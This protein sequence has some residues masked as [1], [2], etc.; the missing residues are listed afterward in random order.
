MMKN[1]VLLLLTTATVFC[2]LTVRTSRAQAPGTVLWTFSKA[3]DLSG[4]ALDFNGTVYTVGSD[5]IGDTNYMLYALNPTGSLKWS[6]PCPPLY[7]GDL[8]IGAD[9]SIYAHLF[10]SGAGGLYAFD[11]SGSIRW[12]QTNA[13]TGS[14]SPAIG[15][16]GTVYYYSDARSPVP[17]ASTLCAIRPDGT[18]KWA[19]PLGAEYAGYPVVGPDGTIYAVSGNAIFA[20]NPDGTEKWTNTNDWAGF[21][22]V[23][24]E[25]VLYM[26]AW[27]DFFVAVNPN[28]TIRW[29]ASPGGVCFPVIGPDGIIYFGTSSAIYALT[30]EGTTN[31]VISI[32]QNMG[33]P[34]LGPDGA[35]YV[36]SGPNW[37]QT[38]LYCL[39]LD[40]ST[41]WQAGL[42]GSLIRAPIVGP[43][44]I[45]YCFTWDRLG[46][47]GGRV[48][49]IKGGAGATPAPWPSERGNFRNTARDDRPAILL[50]LVPAGGSVQLSL[51]GEAGMPFRLQSSTNLWAW[52]TAASGTFTNASAQLTVPAATNSNS[53][54]FRL[55]VP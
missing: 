50:P 20:I 16:D 54:F 26:G 17:T 7:K 49:A 14:A 34:A 11:P 18:I 1:R 48:Y 25:G 35:L 33:H 8:A 19:Y 4:L 52:G 30:P 13:A 22:A 2:L 55:A 45:V 15:A 3:Y 23:S 9:G 10:E 32:G 41:N 51:R 39:K 47:T 40:G 44:G 43:D 24:P 31:R 21:R 5:T 27:P 36:T 42:V 38:N 37:S 12:V 29:K 28:G 53:Q 46:G 6:V